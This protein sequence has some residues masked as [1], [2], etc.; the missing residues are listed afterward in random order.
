[1]K[2]KTPTCIS[3]FYIYKLLI[4][5]FLFSLSEFVLAQNVESVSVKRINLLEKKENNTKDEIDEMLRII[6]SLSVEQ[7]SLALIHLNKIP[8]KIEKAEYY[9][10]WINYFEIL[11]SGRSGKTHLNDLEIV[12]I[13]FLKVLALVGESLEMYSTCSDSFLVNSESNLIFIFLNYLF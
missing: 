4:V 10:A 1:M 13:S 2:S 8:L 9:S 7:D 11:A 5:F 3:Y 12:K 6:E